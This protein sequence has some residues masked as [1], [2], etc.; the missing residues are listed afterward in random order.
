MN[1]LIECPVE[2]LDKVYDE[3]MSWLGF[4]KSQVDRLFRRLQTVGVLKINRDDDDGYASNISMYT[5]KKIK[6]YIKVLTIDKETK[7]TLVSEKEDKP[8]IKLISKNDKEDDE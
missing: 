4:S 5:N 2:D 7:K 8:I 3:L 6:D 1:E